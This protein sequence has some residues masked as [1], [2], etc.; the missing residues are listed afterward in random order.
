MGN[1][2]RQKLIYSVSSGFREW[3]STFGA[4]YLKSFCMMY[5]TKCSSPVTAL[6]CGPFYI[7]VPYLRQTHFDHK[8]TMNSFQ[9]NGPQ[10]V[11]ASYLK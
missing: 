6:N 9:S 3:K 11:V 2:Q 8:I 10:I 1:L 7:L 5:L 4:E